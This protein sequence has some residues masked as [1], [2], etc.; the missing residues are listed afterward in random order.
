MRNFQKV[1]DIPTMPLLH[2][3][4]R[5]PQLWNENRFRTEFPNTPHVD[6]DD[7]WLRFSDPKTCTT[8]S[9]VIGD[10]RPI[11]YPAANVLTAAKPL[12]L[13]LMGAVGGYEL[14]RLLISRIKPG[15][16]I[17]PHRDDA[18]EYVHMKDISRYH[19][20]LQGLPGS[21]YHCG[22][23]GEEETVNMQ[24]GEVWWFNAHKLHSVV[25]NSADDRIHLLVDIKTWH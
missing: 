1:G 12:V 7:I 16:V 18:G 4:V 25:N 15:G 6:V 19:V 3:V 17:L 13:Q 10:D 11:W 5:N 23:K 20:C 14:G 22:E 21:L 9:N 24:T 8:T 2:Q